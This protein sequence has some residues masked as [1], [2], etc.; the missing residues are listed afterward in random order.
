MASLVQNLFLM[1]SLMKIFPSVLAYF[2]CCVTSYEQIGFL[3]NTTQEYDDCD[4]TLGEPCSG[5]FATPPKIALLLLKLL[6]LC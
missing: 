6:D 5:V 1:E 3:A 4:A 2:G